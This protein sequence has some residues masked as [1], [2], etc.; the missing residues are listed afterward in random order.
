MTSERK[1]T[2]DRKVVEVKIVRGKGD[3]PRRHR[4]RRKHEFVRIVRARGGGPLRT[5]AEH[6]EILERSNKN[7]VSIGALQSLPL[8]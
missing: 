6:R 4:K 3:A 8:G 5:R 1:I 7:R 2:G